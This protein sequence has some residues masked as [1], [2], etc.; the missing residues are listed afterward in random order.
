M[1]CKRRELKRRLWRLPNPIPVRAYIEA[2]RLSGFTW[3]EARAEIEVLFWK[4]NGKFWELWFQLNVVDEVYEGKVRRRGILV[5]KHT[6]K[7][8]EDKLN[9][10]DNRCFYC[11]R[12]GK[13]TKDHIVPVALGGLNII[14]NI[15]PSCMRCNR[16]KHT[17]MLHKFKE[18]AMLKML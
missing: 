3:E 6:E 10:Y 15:V 18:G 8:W 17:K 4:D 13:L 12:V 1:E 2:L 11:G 7:E 5:G 16:K 9:Q 14:D